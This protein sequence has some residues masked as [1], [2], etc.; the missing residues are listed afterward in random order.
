M[1]GNPGGIWIG[2]QG[3]LPPMKVLGEATYGG[4]S[5]RVLCKTILRGERCDT[6]GSNFSQHTQCGGVS[7]GPSLGISDGRRG[8][9]KWQGQHKRQ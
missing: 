4:A 2:D 1:T 7:S 5:G 9:E 3:P 8:C 6:G